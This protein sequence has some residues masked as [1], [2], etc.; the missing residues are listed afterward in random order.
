MQ[1]FQPLRRDLNG[2]LGYARDIAARSVKAG[3][4]AELDR[5]AACFEHDRNRRGRRLCR[6]CRRSP[7]AA[8]TATSR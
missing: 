7:V 1:Q 6:K 2:Q 4:E 5:V 8:I 3:D